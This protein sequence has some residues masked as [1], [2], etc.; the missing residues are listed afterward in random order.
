MHANKKG[1]LPLPFKYVLSP[2]ETKFQRTYLKTEKKGVCGEE[3][4]KITL[5]LVGFLKQMIYTCKVV[6]HWH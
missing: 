4:R 6:K 3:C 1:V 2:G 5:L